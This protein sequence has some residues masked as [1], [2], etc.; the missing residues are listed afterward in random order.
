MTDFNAI[1]EIDT[2]PTSKRREGWMQSL[3]SYSPAIDMTEKLR[4]RI[5]ITLQAASLEGAAAEGLALLRGATG[6][7]SAFE[8]MT[9]AEYDRRADEIDEPAYY[10]ASDAA[11]RLWIS[12]QRVQQLAT[13]GALPSLRIGE[14]TLAFPAQAVRQFA[15]QRVSGAQLRAAAENAA[16]LDPTLSQEVRDLLINLPGGVHPPGAVMR[17]GQ[18][19][20]AHRVLELLDRVGREWPKPNMLLVHRA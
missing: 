5:V 13:S 20:A 3:A 14:R 7:L 16:Y 18:V 10:G 17:P 11:D 1:G 15:A 4:T 8:V 6:Q 9:T 19:A 12:R 2:A